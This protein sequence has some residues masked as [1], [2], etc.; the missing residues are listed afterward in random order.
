MPSVAA[1]LVLLDE[2]PPA[3]RPYPTARVA[4][5]A[6]RAERGRA[7]LQND[8]CG[9]VRAKQ[10]PSH[11]G[12]LQPRDAG[13]PRDTLRRSPPVDG[14][15]ICILTPDVTLPS[16]GGEVGITSRGSVEV[17]APLSTVR[18][19]RRY[20]RRPGSRAARSRRRTARCRTLRTSGLGRPTQFK[21]HSARS[22]VPPAEDE[23]CAARLRCAVGSQHQATRPSFAR[24]P[25]PP[26][27]RDVLIERRHKPRRA[28]A[29]A[30]A[31]EAEHQAV[32]V[33]HDHSFDGR[34]AGTANTRIVVEVEVDDRRTRR[35]RGRE[36]MEQ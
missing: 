3:Q 25:A 7:A 15:G 5:R 4:S 20:C 28:V 27:F 32:S 19:A 11:R 12:A 23:R 33:A 13:Q 14:A 31:R 1:I 30:V 17:V 2:P 22:L 10:A 16:P 34:T 8:Q 29:V 35:T 26:P 6:S 18:G 24:G 9:R 21:V 36:T